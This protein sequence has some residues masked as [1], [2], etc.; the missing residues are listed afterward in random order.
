M[1]RITAKGAAVTALVL[2]LVLGAV[3]LVGR[4]F[5]SRG[6]KFRAQAN[7]NLRRGNKRVAARKT[8]IDVDQLFDGTVAIVL[9]SRHRSMMR[10]LRS[11]RIQQFTVQDAIPKSTV[12][13]D[14][15]LLVDGNRISDAKVA[16]HYAHIVV[17]H[18][19]AHARGPASETLL[20]LEDDLKICLNRQYMRKR[21][22]SLR[23]DLRKI[24]K[25]WDLLFLGRCDDKCSRN[26]KVT[27][28]LVRTRDAQCLHAYA[29][30]RRA[31]KVILSQMIPMNAPTDTMYRLLLRKNLLRAYACEPPLFFQNRERLGSTLHNTDNLLVCREEWP[32][33]RGDFEMANNKISVLCATAE[34]YCYV[35]DA[36]LAHCS[37][38]PSRPLH[39]A[40]RQLKSAAPIPRKLRVP[41]DSTILVQYAV[42]SI[43]A[44]TVLRV[45]NA[46]HSTPE[47]VFVMVDKKNGSVLAVLAHKTALLGIVE[48]TID[49][50]LL[51]TV[52]IS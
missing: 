20:I 49:P 52:S 12:F 2:L 35:D 13:A 6:M 46:F 38:G 42:P 45:A 27:R 32:G 39:Y 43:D 19:F 47:R 14:R 50:S 34:N 24:K 29:V 28:F 15:E 5:I 4:L 40:L 25:P 21:L 11:Y 22:A 17:L 37:K 7:Q 9:P 30:T 31:A 18:R 33:R 44:K 3:A 16:C 41:H 36:L 26:E 48:N 1:V 51:E 8:G 23:D 10:A